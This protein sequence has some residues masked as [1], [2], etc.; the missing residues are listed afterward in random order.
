[1]GQHSFLVHYNDRHTTCISTKYVDDTTIWEAYD[2]SSV[3]SSTPLKNKL[4]IGLKRLT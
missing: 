4:N 1:M 2:S 3:D